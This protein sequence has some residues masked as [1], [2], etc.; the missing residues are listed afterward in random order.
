MSAINREWALEKVISAMCAILA[1]GS[2]ERVVI[3]VMQ[4][5]KVDMLGAPPAVPPQEQGGGKSSASDAPEVE[6]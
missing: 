3:E 4:K 2:R 5:L 1:G 6:R